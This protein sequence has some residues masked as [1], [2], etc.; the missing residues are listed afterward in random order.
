MLLLLPTL[1]E[2]LPDQIQTRLREKEKES[3]KEN[4]ADISSGIVALNFSDGI[5]R[6]PCSFSLCV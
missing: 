4:K 6:I 5:P 1:E 3:R 2:K